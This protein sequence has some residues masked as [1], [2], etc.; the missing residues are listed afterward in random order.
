MPPP[1][2]QAEL[3]DHKKFQ[4]LG[5]GSNL[6]GSTCKTLGKPQVLVLV[7]I[8]Q[9]AISGIRSSSQMMDKPGGTQLLQMF[10]LKKQNLVAVDPPA[11]SITLGGGFVENPFISQKVKV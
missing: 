3:T 10:Q 8:Y 7:S 9:G 1:L 6:C 4:L 2:R 11:K 5:L